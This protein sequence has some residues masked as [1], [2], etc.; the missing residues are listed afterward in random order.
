MVFE[1]HHMNPEDALK[2]H[3]DLKSRQ[4]VAIHH[5]TFQLTAEPPEEPKELLLKE[6]GRLACPP[7]DF[8]ILKNGEQLI[9]EQ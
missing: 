9:F 3:L 8:L 7:S 6:R 5:S 1:T 4:S 2:A